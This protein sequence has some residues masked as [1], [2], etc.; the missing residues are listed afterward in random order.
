MRF[1]DLV[2]LPWPG[3][4]PNG[5]HAGYAGSRVALA[6][7]RGVQ[8]QTVRWPVF[9]MSLPSGILTVVAWVEYWSDEFITPDLLSCLSRISHKVSVPL[10]QV[11]IDSL[12]AC[13]NRFVVAV[14]KNGSCHT[15]EYRLNDVQKLCTGW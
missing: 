4:M 10:G 3:A 14:V 6:E 2:P 12:H 5:S 9:L 1:G 15:A 11:P 8:L 13:I 7:C